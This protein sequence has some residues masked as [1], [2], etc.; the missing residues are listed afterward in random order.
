[1]PN[2]RVHHPLTRSSRRTISTQSRASHKTLV[3]TVVSL[4][5]GNST[6]SYLSKSNMSKL[7]C[8]IYYVKLRLF[9]SPSQTISPSVS[10]DA[11]ASPRYFRTFFLCCYDEVLLNARKHRCRRHAIKHYDQPINHKRISKCTGFFI[12]NLLIC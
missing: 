11:S 1:M 6:Y 9:L 5:I 4:S 12:L 3:R 8:F 7:I 2:V 10:V